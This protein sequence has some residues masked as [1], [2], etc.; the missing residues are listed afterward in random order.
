[1]VAGHE[2]CGRVVVTGPGCTLAPGTR[3]VVYHIAGCGLCDACLRGYMVGTLQ[4]TPLQCAA[5][6]LLQG[7]RAGGARLAGGEPGVQHSLQYTVQ[8]DGGHAPHL[9][10]WQRCC[11]ALPPGL[12]YTDGALAACGAGTAWEA[13]RSSQFI[14]S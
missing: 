11:V 7:E 6:G 4:E 12:S 3:V 14:C 9:L 10:T 1:M 2:P 5:A 13:L 8:V